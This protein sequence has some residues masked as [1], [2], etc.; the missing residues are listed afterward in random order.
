MT[1]GQVVTGLTGAG[2]KC[3]T[4]TPYAVC[5]NG[6]LAV[7]VLTGKHERPPILSLQSTGRAAAATA[8]ISSDLSEV[9]RLAHVNEE[10]QI[11]E[12]FD[13]QAGRTSAKTT[14]G[15]WRVEWSAEVDT[16]E[17]GAQLTLLDTLCKAN[18][19]TE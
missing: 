11:G 18:C 9:L 13:R 10:A 19:L 2:Y 4:D 12:W 5:A 3:G 15:T 1:A 17:P 7:W 14:I 8:A 6:P 16:D